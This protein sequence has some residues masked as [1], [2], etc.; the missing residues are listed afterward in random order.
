MTAEDSIP[1]WPTNV[2]SSIVTDL[3][4]IHELVTSSTNDVR[5]TKDE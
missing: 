4:L 1:Y 2:F 5:I 3:V